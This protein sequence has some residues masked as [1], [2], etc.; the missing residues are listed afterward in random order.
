MLRNRP[1]DYRA[2]RTATGWEL[3]T[4][5]A[6]LSEHRT[7]TE[8]TRAAAAHD[9]QIGRKRSLLLS[10][11]LAVLCGLLLIPIT[12]MREVDNPAYPA[13]REM[14]DRMEAAYRE[15]D[16][17]T[18]DI[19]S[20]V[21]DKD[22]FA[23][24]EFRLSR[25]GVEADY[26]VLAGQHDGDCY[27]LRWVRF[28]VPFVARLLPRLECEPGGSTL[29]FSPTAYEAIAVNLS[30]S[31]AL[32]WDAVLPDPIKLAS[33]FFPGFLILAAAGFHQLVGFSIAFLRP[34]PARALDVERVGEDRTT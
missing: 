4:D 12:S 8:A 6:I 9:Q 23:G 10:G 24:G 14:A 18:A 22:G 3:R 33:W 5:E 32:Q 7:F 15:V 31:D 34:P 21:T 13:A 25:A 26:N 16:P 29:N 28:E 19:E 11:A 20:F 17:G 1:H 2:V 27:V 30:T